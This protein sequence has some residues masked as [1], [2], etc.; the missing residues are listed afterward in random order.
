MST[1]RFVPRAY[2]AWIIS[3]FVIAYEY[4]L[5]NAI[6]YAITP[7]SIDF[8]MHQGQIHDILMIFFYVYI[9]TELPLGI[10]LDKIGSRRI[11]TMTTLVS[12]LSAIVLALSHISSVIFIGR[13]ILGVSSGGAILA[14]FL[15]I[16]AWFETNIPSFYM[17]ISF[18]VVIFSSTIASVHLSQWFPASHWRLLFIIFAVLG[19]LLCVWIWKVLRDHPPM[20]ISAR[21]R[22][23]KESNTLLQ[24]A[25]LVLK[26][27]SLWLNNLIAGLLYV[28]LILFSSSW[29]RAYLCQYAHISLA[30]ANVMIDILFI[31]AIIGIP[32]IGLFSDY[33]KLRR[34]PLLICSICLLISFLILVKNSTLP[35]WDIAGLMFVIGFMS[36]SFILCFSIMRE[37]IPQYHLGFG[38]ATTHMSCLALAVFV[39]LEAI[40]EVLKIQGNINPE[41]LALST[42]PEDFKFAI[43]IIACGIGLASILSFFVKETYGTP[44]FWS[45][46][47]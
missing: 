4:L 32:L 39:F 28:P 41:T 15:L 38:F 40:F 47:I 42:V 29:C 6:H 2:H 24:A 19:L 37:S 27:P 11:L 13:F 46:H 25:I 3:L 18:S 23:S 36:G 44:D 7:L 5:Q 30:S 45:N 33:L 16:M 31:G 22:Q 9:V 21:D 20:Q 26:E 12:S 34:L 1:N 17:G 8:A 10:L 35:K 14:S 43:V